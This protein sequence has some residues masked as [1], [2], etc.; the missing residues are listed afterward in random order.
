MVIYGQRQ[1]KKTWSGAVFGPFRSPK[2]NIQYTKLIWRNL[3]F[4]ISRPNFVIANNKLFYNQSKSS[5]KNVAS[6]ETSFLRKMQ[7]ISWHSANGAIPTW[8]L[9][10]QKGGY[11]FFSKIERS[12]TFSLCFTRLFISTKCR[13]SRV[14]YNPPR[15]ELRREL[16]GTT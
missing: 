9:Q 16:V 4:V 3:S 1:Q 2:Q 11:E 14:A 15:H 5:L 6:Q 8:D 12:S 7:Q 10:E 13:R